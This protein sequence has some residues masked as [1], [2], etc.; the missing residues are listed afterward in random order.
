MRA[1]QAETPAVPDRLIC[2]DV[3]LAKQ[4]EQTL[5]KSGSQGGGEG[6]NSMKYSGM[7]HKLMSLFM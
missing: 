2:Q 6:E 3:N 1:P 4:T 5:K 7:N